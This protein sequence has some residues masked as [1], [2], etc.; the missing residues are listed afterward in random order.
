MDGV[1]QQVAALGGVGILTPDD[2]KDLKEG[3]FR[4]YNLMKDGN[5]HSPDEICL[6]AGKNGVPAREGL[7][8]MRELRKWFVVE[9][10]RLISSGTGASTR[11]TWWYRLVKR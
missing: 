1:T 3:V 6:A 5:C 8:R 4:V 11:R 7:R 10:M 9:P 2:L